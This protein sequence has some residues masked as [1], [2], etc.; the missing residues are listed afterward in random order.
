MVIVQATHMIR[1]G[2]MLVNLCSM[3][4]IFF[5]GSWNTIVCPGQVS[6]PSSDI[7]AIVC[8]PARPCPG[9][10]A[11]GP[12]SLPEGVTCAPNAT[13]RGQSA[14]IGTSVG[15]DQVRP[16]SVERQMMHSLGVEPKFRVPR[17]W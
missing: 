17:R 14:G 2:A 7:A 13:S 6:P 4:P 11:H 5:A 16:P 10:V 1:P 9:S 15:S 12:S 8:S 3:Y